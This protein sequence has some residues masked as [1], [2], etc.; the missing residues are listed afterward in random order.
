[1][2]SKVPKPI[3]PALAF[4]IAPVCFAGA[5]RQ[6]VVLVDDGGNGGGGSG[7]DD[8]GPFGDRGGFNC[9]RLS[10][11]SRPPEAILM[12]DRSQAMDTPFGN[13]TSTRLQS[14]QTILRNLVG[15]YQGS[16]LF[17]Y[18]EFPATGQ[19]QCGQGGPGVPG[20]GCCAGEIFA[21]TKYSIMAFDQY[22]HGCDRA[23]C[24]SAQRP[25]DDA[26]S[27]CRVSYT[28]LGDNGTS[29]FVVLVTGGEPMCSS[30]PTP[31]AGCTD[32]QNAAAKLSN[33]EVKTFIVAVGGELASS[34]CLDILATTGGV[35]Q[36]GSSPR[37]YLETGPGLLQSDL[38]TIFEII[39][40][41]AC[42][43]DLRP[44]GIADPDKVTVTFNGING[45]MMVP[46]DP[47]N[48]WE[49]DNGSPFKIAL[50][51]QACM[52]YTSGQ[53]QSIDILSG[54]GCGVN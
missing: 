15:Y 23:P 3:A 43:F 8:G 19:A 7:S 31:G 53:V 17:G 30:D 46:H 12:V 45:R 16:V 54:R 47:A 28:G 40:E 9:D 51:G 48:G 36:Q 1:V 26:L 18:G 35:P 41:N 39:A 44:P 33:D 42:H 2:P 14:V 32:A 24:A 38:A 4:L 25:I 10:P 22:I 13:G 49:L 5:C 20:D 11:T 6:T 37:F 21:P 50:Y 52:T 29:R 34:T 27:R